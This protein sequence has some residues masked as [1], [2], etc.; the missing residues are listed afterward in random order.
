MLQPE[1]LPIKVVSFDVGIKNMA[2]CVFQTSNSSE[3]L[4]NI[5]IIDWNVIDLIDTPPPN[6]KL[7]QAVM[8]NNKTCGKKAKFERSEPSDCFCEKHAKISNYFMPTRER[9]P[10]YIKKL[11][12]GELQE[13][14]LKE[15]ITN[16]LLTDKR[17]AII[18]KIVAYYSVSCLVPIVC[19]KKKADDCS[20]ISIGQRIKQSFNSIPSLQNVTHVLIENQ[21]S[22]IASRMSIIQGLLTQY[23]I[24]R[25]S[26]EFN[27]V[28]EFISSKNKL[29][30]FDEK[31]IP[32]K[33]QPFRRNTDNTSP[34]P[35]YMPNNLLKNTPNFRNGCRFSIPRRKMIWR[36]V[37]YKECGTFLH[38]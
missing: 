19:A 37:F 4:D 16:V 23:F 12:I 22:T 29:K 6:N 33:T 17:P 10:K 38:P 27:L 3:N 7:C 9:S 15:K 21:I 36:T 1:I 11:K 35:S 5:E 20:I 14:V 32:Q 34:I 24:M 18:D 28:L 8:K 26:D 31:T 30:H 2:Y 25:H 13:L